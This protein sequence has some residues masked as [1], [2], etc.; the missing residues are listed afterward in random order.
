MFGAVFGYSSVEA[1]SP[2]ASDRSCGG[3]P[4][5]APGESEA[6][7]IQVGELER[8]YRLHLPTSYDPA[9]PVPLVLVFHGYTGNVMKPGNEYTA[10]GQHGDLRGYIVAY[11]QA[12]GFE[13]NGASD[14]LVERFRLQRA[15]Q[16]RGSNL[17]R[18]GR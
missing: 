15:L 14:H 7:T 2:R 17:Y 18:P 11:P 1:G 3:T 13:V 10:F 8:E 9:T 4:P 5:L 6:R 12:T 16:G